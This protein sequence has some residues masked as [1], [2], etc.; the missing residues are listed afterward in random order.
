MDL[1]SCRSLLRSLK[2]RAANSPAGAII[3]EP[4]PGGDEAALASKTAIIE[5]L[6]ANR[7]RLGGD[8]TGEA[9][10]VCVEQM[11]AADL[12]GHPPA[13]E[14]VA[15]AGLVFKECIMCIQIYGQKDDGAGGER[16]AL[17]PRSSRCSPCQLRRRERP[18]SFNLCV[19]FFIIKFLK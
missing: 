6:L 5:T 11:L 3:G 10:C 17:S 18:P 8:V 16:E 1:S 15:L 19:N 13:W 14:F 2:R 9:V 12:A 7:C 4:P